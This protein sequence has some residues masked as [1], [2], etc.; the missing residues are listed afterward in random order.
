MKFKTKILTLPLSATLIIVVGSLI[1]F[2]TGSRAFEQLDHL[3]HMETP[4]LSALIRANTGIEQ[5]RQLMKSVVSERGANK[6]KDSE[7]AAIA[8][9][10]ALALMRSLDADDH[11]LSATFESYQATATTAVKAL[12][13]QKDPGNAV[14]E[15]QKASASLDKLMPE[16]VKRRLNAIDARS[17]LAAESARFNLGAGVAT[18]ALVLLA[19]AVI[20]TVVVRSVWRDLGDDP[21]A[22][23]AIV[24]DIAGG[25][26]TQ[27]LHVHHNDKHSLLSALHRMQQSLVDVVSHVRGNSENVAR[28][29][30][31]IAD[32]NKGLSH[33]TEEQTNALRHTASTMQELSSTVRTTA[34]N[35]RQANVLAQGASDAAAKGGEVV[36]QVVGTMR[37]IND[38]S[39]KISDI[40]GVI[41]G[42]AFQTNILALNAAVEAARSGEQGRG[43][44]VVAIEVRTLAQRSAEAA[45]EIKKLIVGSVEQVERGTTLVDAAGRTMGEV[46]ASIKRVSDI[47]GEISSASVAQSSGVTQVG[48]SISHMEQ[49]T[50][51]NTALVE[52]SAVAAQTLKQQS[53]DLLQAVAVFKLGIQSRASGAAAV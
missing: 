29:S 30:S 12:V 31:Q 9:R 39:K 28:A 7:Q 43:F 24:H 49:V 19:L 2:L 11:G 36:G 25:E 4:A 13:D 10:E 17:V 33:R 20:S 47:V 51:K 26:L 48:E 45:K 38:S 18:G 15:M 14:A 27:A 22:L 3:Q 23:R 50:Q 16:E 53:R 52:Q 34:D 1:G 21:L 42:I 44:A 46:V 8:V 35:A 41:D 37:G 32:G 6:L 40:I 5:F